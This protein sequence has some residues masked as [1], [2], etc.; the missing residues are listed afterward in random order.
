M[1]WRLT[2]ATPS[3]RT[4]AFPARLAISAASVQLALLRPP[5]GGSDQPLGQH[6]LA[7]VRKNESIGVLERANH[8]AQKAFFIAVGDR[9]AIFTVDAHHLLAV[10]D[11]AAFH[12]GWPVRDGHQAVMG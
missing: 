11:D 2:G 8:F 9:A 10:G 5:R 1:S 4:F 6:T 7:V 3:L 12:R